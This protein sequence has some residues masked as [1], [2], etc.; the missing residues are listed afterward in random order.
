MDL[1]MQQRIAKKIR[2]NQLRAKPTVLVRLNRTTEIIVTTETK[3]KRAERATKVGTVTTVKS[4]RCQH[5]IIFF[6]ADGCGVNLSRDAPIVAG[7]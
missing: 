1:M 4:A 2:K 7:S 5:E 6:I 3:S